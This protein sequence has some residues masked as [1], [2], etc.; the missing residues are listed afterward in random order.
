ME[1][2][3][4]F[5]I[6]FGVGAVLGLAYVGIVAI[7]RTIRGSIWAAKGFGSAISDG[8]RKGIE[9]GKADVA[10]REAR[11]KERLRAQP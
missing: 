1:F 5:F 11:K 8:V 4:L 7:Y 10:A 2:L 9:Q 6:L 3:F